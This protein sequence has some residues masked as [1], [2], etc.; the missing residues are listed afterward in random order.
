M[1][2]TAKEWLALGDELG[3]ELAKVLTPGPWK[4]DWGNKSR[5]ANCARYWPEDIDSPCPVPDPITIDWNTAM[6]WFRKTPLLCQAVAMKCIYYVV[7]EGDADEL[8]EMY[9]WWLT[10]AQPKHYLIAAA[11]A[12]NESYCYKR[13]RH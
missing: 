7:M 3:V 11:M 4:H 5:C 12:G 1:T 2:R 6:E 10:F 8:S 13:R 9:L